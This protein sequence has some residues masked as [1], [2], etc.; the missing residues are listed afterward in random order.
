MKALNPEKYT[1]GFELFGLDYMITKD[2]K[3]Y[4]IEI[5]TNPSLT[6]MSP[7]T[8]RVITSVLENVMR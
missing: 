7:V 1:F 2:L 4:L 6:I 5:N 8:G 3:L